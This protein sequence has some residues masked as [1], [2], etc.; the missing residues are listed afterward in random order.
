M[1]NESVA[2]FGNEFA[3]EQATTESVDRVTPTPLHPVTGVP[4]I[5][6]DHVKLG[7]FVPPVW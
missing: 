1:T 7:V 3:A 4:L 2:P 5:W 6:S